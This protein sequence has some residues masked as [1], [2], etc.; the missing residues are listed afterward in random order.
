MTLLNLAELTV[1]ELMEKIG[2]PKFPGPA[3][4]SAVAVGAAMG[5]ALMEM[6]WKATLKKNPLLVSD[7][8]YL[9]KIEGL[10]KRLLSLATEDMEGYNRY[11][12]AV[13]LKKTDPKGYDEA[14]IEGTMP[15]V[16]IAR[17]SAAL[18]ELLEE[19]QMKCFVKV[20]GDLAGSAT[21]LN[22]AVTAC[23]LAAR[24]NVNLMLETPHKE[25]V[26]KALEE[27]SR[28]GQGCYEKVI[29]R[30]QTMMRK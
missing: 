3:S 28:I 23:V 13:G 29:H 7:T 4:G 16:D 30:I 22:G 15:L 18:L 19:I 1:T 9:E 25:T 12:K 8:N 14:L 6:S 24:I 21:L 26:E 20:Q 10:G 11:I 17:G 2:E 5:A 27:A